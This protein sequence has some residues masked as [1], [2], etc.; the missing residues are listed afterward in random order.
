MNAL[1][2]KTAIITGASRG[3]GRAT[4]ELF[5][6]EGANLVLSAH[7][8]IKLLNE[9]AKTK[10]VLVLQADLR[11]KEDIKKLV[12]DA[13][14][15]FSA[16]DILVNNAGTFEVVD[17]EEIEESHFDEVMS[18]DLKGAFFLTQR[19]IPIF[20]KQGQGKIIN[21]SSLSGKIGSSSAPHYAAAKA[22]IIALTKSLARKYGKF[23]INV[24]AI[25]PS[26]INTDMVRKIPQERLDKLL[27]A[28]PL[29]RLGSPDEVAHLILFLAS[30]A[31]D[32][33]TGQTVSI[34]G[35]MSMI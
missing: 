18:L 22:G 15:K 30:S 35:G 11:Q 23:N 25:A 4:A 28:V 10:Q 21:V 33:I 8:N 16:I 26:L 1:S 20:L 5:L 32:Y 19:V 27:D 24:N 34:D 6:K 7:Q 13:F 17:F 31:A 29:K 3:I 2:G 12:K 9:L 14:D